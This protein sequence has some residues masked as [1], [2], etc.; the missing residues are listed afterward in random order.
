M[1]TGRSAA[2][3]RLIFT[4]GI[5]CQVLQ[6]VLTSLL[7][8]NPWIVVWRASR[9]AYGRSHPWSHR[10]MVIKRQPNSKRHKKLKYLFLLAFICQR[11]F[12]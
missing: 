10:V 9:D 7:A 3:P 2:M 8:L 12:L 1:E 6:I 11:Y 4:S 5:R